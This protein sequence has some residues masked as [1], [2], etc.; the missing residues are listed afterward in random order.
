MLII[1]NRDELHDR[2]HREG[3][4]AILYDHTGTNCL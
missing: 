1:K 2:Y 4:D 3:Q